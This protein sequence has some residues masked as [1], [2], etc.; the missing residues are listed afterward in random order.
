MNSWMRL[1][2][3]IFLIQLLRQDGRGTVNTEECPGCHKKG[4]NPIFRCQECAGGVLL[5]KG[6]CVDKHTDNPLHVIFVR[7]TLGQDRDAG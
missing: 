6:C 4:H 1:L 5:C 3:D 2:R 7:S